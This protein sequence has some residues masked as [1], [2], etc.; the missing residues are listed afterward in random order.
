MKKRPSS[1]EMLRVLFVEKTPKV[2]RLGIEFSFDWIFGKNKKSIHLFAGSSKLELPNINVLRVHGV[3]DKFSG[4]VEDILEVTPNLKLFEK[5]SLD[6]GR[7][8]ESIT[9]RELTIL[10]KLNKLH[11]IERASLMFKED[12]IN[13]LQNSPQIMDIQLKRIELT[14]DWLQQGDVQLSSLATKFINKIFD[15]S[16]NSLQILELPP[17]GW[18]S[19]LVLPKFENLQKLVLTH[20]E[21]QKDED[22]V[23]CMFPPKFD[24]ADS[25]PNL[26]QLSKIISN[27]NK[28]ISME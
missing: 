12:M 28:C 10:H 20:D 18:L 5:C 7:L 19:G 23:Y 17:L 14:V 6:N 2:K 4:I 16:R 21:E 26:Q 25:F 13:C 1:V 11:C 9:A 8:S 24:M 15:S 22:E 3:F 27:N